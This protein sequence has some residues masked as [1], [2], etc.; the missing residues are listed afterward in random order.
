MNE[1][2]ILELIKSKSSFDPAFYGAIGVIAGAVITILGQL[3]IE[4]F[5]NR[6]LNKLDKSR[7]KLLKIMLNDP[8]YNW[9]DIDSLSSVIGATK[10]KTR[11]L[12]IRIGARGSVKNFLHDETWGLISRNPF[13]RI[14]NDN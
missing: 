8:K 7:M 1:E 13:D 3:A 2:I 11:D 5:K 9:R 14:E 12:L 4:Y 6:K 10:S